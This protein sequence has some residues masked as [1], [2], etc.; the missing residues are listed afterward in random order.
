MEV[1]LLPV[2]TSSTKS[3]VCYPLTL[4]KDEMVIYVMIS[5]VTALLFPNLPAFIADLD[6]RQT[7]QA[8][9][10]PR[11][12]TLGEVRQQQ[13]SR[14]FVEIGSAAPHSRYVDTSRA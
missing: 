11:L 5:V 4:E 13:F 10:A 12:K 2:C 9:L 6:R 8:N 3:G 7:R 14:N 1:R